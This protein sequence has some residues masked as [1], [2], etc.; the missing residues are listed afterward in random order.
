MNIKAQVLKKAEELGD[1]AP[2]FFGYAAKTIESW[3]KK[4]NSIPLKAVE[5]VLNEPQTGSAQSSDQ[6]T[7]LPKD[8][9]PQGNAPATPPVQNDARPRPPYT[10]ENAQTDIAAMVEHFNAKISPYIQAVKNQSDVNANAI[11]AINEQLR[12]LAQWK[13][14]MERLV[15]SQQ[16]HAQ[17]VGQ[18]LASQ[19]QDTFN[20]LANPSDLPSR[21]RP[22]DKAQVIAEFNP[23]QQS[24]NGNPLDTGI[25]PSAEDRSRSLNS[26]AEREDPRN[27]RKP[28]GP[29]TPGPQN[30]PGLTGWSKP[31]PGANR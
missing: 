18:L 23:N 8:T 3:K 26:L 6:V 24:Q 7:P 14:N 27:P 1:R 9:P 10:I 4:P 15:P 28:A 11:T 31:W 17:T 12:E 5:K 30:A 16:E 2:A 29:A 21:L 25:A 22:A 20:Q 13:A 19:P